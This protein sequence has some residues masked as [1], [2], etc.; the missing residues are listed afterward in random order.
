MGW[1]TLVIR[2]TNGSLLVT[3]LASFTRTYPARIAD[4][5][6]ACQRQLATAALG[7]LP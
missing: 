1:P 6:T 5:L 4:E 2:R 7:Q 3:N